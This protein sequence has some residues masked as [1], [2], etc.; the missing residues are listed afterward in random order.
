MYFFFS[1]NKFVL[2]SSVSFDQIEGSRLHFNGGFWS[3]LGWLAGWLTPWITLIYH[4]CFTLKWT[5]PHLTSPC[6]LVY[7]TRLS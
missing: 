1:Q 6:S 2:T 5:E 7:L 3:S 4:M